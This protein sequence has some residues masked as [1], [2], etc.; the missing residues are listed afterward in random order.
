MVKDLKIVVFGC[1]N[2]GKTT[3]CND[4]LEILNAEGYEAELAKSIG[5]NKTV[6]QYI[7][8]MKT[9]LEKDHIVIFDRFPI[10]E[11]STCGRV[12]RN[13]DIFE[14]WD[15]NETLELLESVDLFI[16][17]YPGLFKVLN[18]GEREQMEGVKENALK[19]IDAYNQ[20]AVA[21]VDIGGVVVE[22]NY[23][24]D[25]PEQLYDLINGGE[26]G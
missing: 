19:L 18:W 9:N 17:C 21:L 14:K 22:Y 11:E 10:I 20:M 16:F 6:E 15:N 1:D 23:N 5:A 4:L 8:F 2:T 26:I 3:L 13:N 12:L 7:E 25:T 24:S